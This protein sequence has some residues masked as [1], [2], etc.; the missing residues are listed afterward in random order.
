LHQTQ[1]GKNLG[2]LIEV[3]LHN[4]VQAAACIMHNWH[5]QCMADRE[6]S[7]DGD[8]EIEFEEVEQPS[9]VHGHS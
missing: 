8:S 7:F 2:I 4:F 5:W 9:P 1:W 6:T 3:I